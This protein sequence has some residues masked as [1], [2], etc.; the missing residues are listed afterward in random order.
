MCIDNI[1]GRH[2]QIWVYYT[3]E[4]LLAPS[5]FQHREEYNLAHIARQQT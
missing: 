1:L 2:P 4:Q 3:P 5:I